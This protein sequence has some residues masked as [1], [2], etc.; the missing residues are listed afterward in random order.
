V[1]RSLRLAPGRKVIFTLL[2]PV[3]QD[4]LLLHAIAI[5]VV[6]R[7][8]VVVFEVRR[9]SLGSLPVVVL[10]ERASRG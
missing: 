4:R 5:H 7:V 3:A 10:D 8:I 2:L 6:V 9:I 1:W